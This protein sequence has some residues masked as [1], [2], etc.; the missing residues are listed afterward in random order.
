MLGTTTEC[1]ASDGKSS[2]DLL[3]T[4]VPWKVKTGNNWITALWGLYR[5]HGEEG[6]WE[7]EEGV[8]RES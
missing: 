7:R 4:G 5:Q 8:G 6:L 1:C 2:H 3:S